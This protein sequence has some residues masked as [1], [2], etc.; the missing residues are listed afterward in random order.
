MSQENSNNTKP[1]NKTDESQR[2]S[3]RLIYDTCEYEKRLVESTDPLNYQ[4]FYGKFENCGKHGCLQK[5]NN[6]RYDVVDVES[7]LKNIVRPGSLCGQFKYNP[8]GSN[9]TITA[10]KAPVVLEPSLCPITNHRETY[11]NVKDS[12]HKEWCKDTPSENLINMG[13]NYYSEYSK[14]SNC[15][16]KDVKLDCTA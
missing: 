15:L 14:D 10:D 4:F 7:E 12:G 5:K 1:V 2:S 3:N 13:G 9:S 6:T 16:S 11:P 8:D